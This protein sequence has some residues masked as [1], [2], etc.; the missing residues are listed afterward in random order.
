[1]ESGQVP[2]TVPENYRLRE[3]LTVTVSIIVDE[4]SNVL[5]VPNSAITTQGWQTYVNVVS[6]DG[7]IE[8]RAI[9]TGITDY[10]FTEVTEGL[11]DGEQIVV[12]L[13]TTATTSNTQQEQ[14]QRGMFITGV[15]RMR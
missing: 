15:G 5:L 14:R 12:P 9:R 8:E 11:T 10:Q 13:G 6:P 7:N 3:G 2:T 4:R 1:M